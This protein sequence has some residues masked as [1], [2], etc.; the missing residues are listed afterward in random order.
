MPTLHPRISL[1]NVPEPDIQAVRDAVKVLQDKLVPHLIDL[2]PEERRAL[3]KMGDRTVAFVG[4]ALVYAR[5]HPGMC[6]SFLDIDEFG[7][8]LASV[9]M[10]LGLQRPLD[11]VVDMVE[12]SLLMAGSES[13]S[14]ALAFYESAKAFAKRNV[15][16]AATIADDLASSFPARGS[17]SGAPKGDGNGHE[18]A[19]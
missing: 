14:A 9:E 11:Q 2:G 3:P 7:R 19:R 17:K 18:E 6:P 12:D 10:L 8:G 5:E 15:A 1:N 4:K 13:L 16:G